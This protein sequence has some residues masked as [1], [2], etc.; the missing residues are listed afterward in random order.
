MKGGMETGGGIEG[1]RIGSE[2]G[3]LGG[4]RGG[5]SCGGTAGPQGTGGSSGVWSVGVVC[6][7]SV[8]VVVLTVASVRW[9]GVR[10]Q[11]SREV[12]R[13]EGG[14]DDGV[15]GVDGGRGRDDGPP[16][17]SQGLSY[18]KVGQGDGDAA[19]AFA[20]RSVGG[21]VQVGQGA[22]N[23]NEYAQHERCEI[24]V[25]IPPGLVAG[26]RRRHCKGGGRGREGIGE[27]RGGGEER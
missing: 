18:G 15:V 10:M 21:K 9:G 5:T 11:K 1:G 17:G 2:C 25:G 12:G 24:C 26:R 16:G 20:V 3:K 22:V 23:G 7:S 19:Q 13:G 27:R 4:G 8:V 14:D 6:C